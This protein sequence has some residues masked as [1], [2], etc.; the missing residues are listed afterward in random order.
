MSQARNKVVGRLVGCMHLFAGTD[1]WECTLA[2]DR[3]I[4]AQAHNMLV[5][6]VESYGDS[7]VFELGGWVG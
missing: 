1:T 6:G 4:F 7:F 3:H 2:V 5:E